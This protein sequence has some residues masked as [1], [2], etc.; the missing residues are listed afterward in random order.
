MRVVHK[1]PWQGSGSASPKGCARALAPSQSY[2]FVSNP[3]G[4]RFDGRRP[5]NF[6]EN[7]L[8]LFEV[9]EAKIP[10][11]SDGRP[12]EVAGKIMRSLDSAKPI[13]LGSSDLP[14]LLG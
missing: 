2:R 8:L 5:Q 3:H 1:C 7:L 10:R 13:S 6:P 12:G 4:H 14:R 9:E 11:A